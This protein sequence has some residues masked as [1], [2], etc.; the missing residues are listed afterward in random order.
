MKLY[1]HPNIDVERE[2]SFLNLIVVVRNHDAKICVSFATRGGVSVLLYG[3]FALFVLRS[4]FVQ[5]TVIFQ[6]S[7]ALTRKIITTEKVIDPLV[8]IFYQ[9]I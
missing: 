4:R 6:K 7:F 8:Q 9:A 3:S 5:T 1:V 2:L